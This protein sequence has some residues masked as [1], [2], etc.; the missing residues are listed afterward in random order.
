MKRPSDGVRAYLLQSLSIN[1]WGSSVYRVSVCVCVCV[2]VLIC[3]VMS[4]SLQP[5]TSSWGPRLMGLQVA[6]PL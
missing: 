2:C 6:G 4:D 1:K 3:S 5:I